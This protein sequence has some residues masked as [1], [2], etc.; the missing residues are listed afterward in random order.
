MEKVNES[1]ELNYNKEIYIIYQEIPGISILKP[2]KL[3]INYPK[4]TSPTHGYDKNWF[5]NK[6]LSVNGIFQK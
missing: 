6:L 3:L 4:K 5:Y 2:K 1:L